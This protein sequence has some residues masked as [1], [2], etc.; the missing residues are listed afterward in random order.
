[1]LLDFERNGTESFILW[2]GDSDFSEPVSNLLK[3]ESG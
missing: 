1:M 3:M 2:S